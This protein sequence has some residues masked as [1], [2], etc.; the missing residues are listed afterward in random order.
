MNRTHRSGRAL[1]AVA[2]LCIAGLALAQGQLEKKKVVI[3]A[4]STQGFYSLPLT[5]TDRLG[6]FKQAGLEV[7]IVEFPGGTKAL[8]AVVGGS[9][10]VVSGAYESTIHLQPKGQYLQEFVLMGVYPGLA[11]GLRPDKAKTYKSPK[12][13]KGLKI[14]VTAPG[15]GT[16]QLVNYLLIKDGLKAEDVSIIGVGSGAG[17]VSAMER[18]DIDAISNIDPVMTQVTNSGHAVI[19]VDVRTRAGSEAI[20]GTGLPSASLYA[21]EEFIKK[22]PNTVQALTDA[23]VR[24]LKWLSRA[25]PEQLAEVVPPEWIKVNKEF[26]LAAFKNQREVFSTDGLVSPK[27]AQMQLEVVR[28][29]SEEVRNAKID[30]P[31]TYTNQFVESS[32][33]RIN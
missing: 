30:L 31:R 20:F 11:V 7:E 17:A 6:L 24:G 16:H 5:V 15:S 4:G 14:G 22:N 29:Y 26:Y 23:M 33:K 21:P 1:A 12:D 25:T 18:G 27:A 13:L 2:L 28:Q 8:Q 10:D 19:I 3:A 32:L 9:A